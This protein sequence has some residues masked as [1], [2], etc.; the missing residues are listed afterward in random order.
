MTPAA[1]AEQRAAAAA[2]RGA[3]G[4]L[5]PLED[6]PHVEFAHVDAIRNFARAYG[7]DNPL[8][9]DADY[10][11][12]SVRGG[13]IAPPLFPIA[14]GSAV[15]DAEGDGGEVSALFAALARGETRVASDEWRFERPIRPGTRLERRDVVFAVD[16]DD[17]GPVTVTVR[18]E[19]S[20]R[21][22]LYATR[23]RRRVHTMAAAGRT[24]SDPPRGGYDEVE[25]AEIDRQYAAE[26][27]R[28]PRTRYADEVAV[29]DRLDALVKGP[30]TVTDMIN[31]RSGVGRGPLGAESHRLAHQNRRRRAGLYDRNE[32]GVFDT[33]ERCHWDAAYARSLGHLSAYDYSHTRPVWI[34][35]LLC[36]WMGDGGW[37]AGLTTSVSGHNYLGD[38][39][40]VEGAVT[41]VR[42]LD[43]RAVVEI[44]VATTNQLGIRTCGG[45]ATVHLPARPAVCITR[46]T[47]GAR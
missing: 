25:V 19:Y 15:P 35:H 1:S 8:Y 3:V 39:H 2:L 13:I 34:S 20:E 43:D 28:D 11:R 9:A 33:R 31:Y 6:R 47:N 29:G 45:V 7:D 23:D 4:A 12:Q 27:R 37:L 14:S 30:L 5:L 18:S 21:G 17:S 46:S 24:P 26:T 44:E 40:R 16:D 41:S 32:L 38:L 36:D 10:A 22:V 42:R